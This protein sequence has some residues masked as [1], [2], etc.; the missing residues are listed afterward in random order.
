MKPNAARQQPE[1]I[2]LAAAVRASIDE[3]VRD[4]SEAVS[5]RHPHAASAAEVMATDPPEFLEC[6]A[7]TI[8][9]QSGSPP[10][11]AIDTELYSNCT[12]AS[13]LS[14]HGD[15]R[16]ST[17]DRVGG[18]LGRELSATELAKL[19][20]TFDELMAGVVSMVLDRQTADLKSLDELQSRYFSFLTHDV[21]GSL[22][23]LVLMLEVL[24]RELGAAGDFGELSSDI[25]LM[26]R[27][28][29]ETV[30]KMDRYIQ[31]DRLRRGLVP[32]SRRS[33]EIKAILGAVIS[34]L[35]QQAAEKQ[36]SFDID[37]P[38]GARIDTDPELLRLALA[39]LAENAIRHGGAGIV[40]IRAH[41][42]DGGWVISVSDQG[43]GIEREKLA[44]LL[45]PIRL[46]HLK[47]KG[48]GLT[49]AYYASRRL[50]G[51]IEGESTP[52]GGCTIRL[53]LPAKPQPRPAG[54]P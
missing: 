20:L 47:D 14:S 52:G 4:F 54:V 45:D 39:N 9:G 29:Q 48:I 15:L 3:I 32:V 24:R 38:D 44:C 40:R 16:R 26:R 22:N 50:G 25:D 19:V 43:P 23:G 17:I 37:A 27:S 13:M 21:R 28:V 36:V 41:S 1:F 46:A 10:P 5:R 42:E 7:R 49:I 11:L 12:A 6:V 51:R 30:G 8:S 34:Q 2:E 31:V 33:V 18:S 53:W 35:S